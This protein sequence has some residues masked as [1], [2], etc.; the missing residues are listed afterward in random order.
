MGKL[1]WTYRIATGLFTALIGMGVAMYIVQYDMVAKMFTSLGYPMHLIYPLAAV[2]VLG[3][4]AIWTRKSET[5]ADFAYA[6]FFFELT[7]A[8]MAHVAVSDG[9]AGGAI[10]ALVLVSISFFTQRKLQAA[11]AGEVGLGRAMP[12]AA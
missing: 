7:L 8:V 10:G 12:A 6:G 5:L 11:Q 9:G 2:K 3:L 1:V 4:I